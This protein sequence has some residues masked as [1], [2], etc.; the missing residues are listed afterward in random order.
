MGDKRREF[1]SCRGRPRDAV[2]GMPLRLHRDER[3]TISIVALFTLLTLVILL[4][5]VVNTGQQVDQKIKMQNAADAAS[6]AGGVVLARNMNTLAF[7]NQLLS[8]VF[9]LTAFM[10][11]AGKRRA[12]SLTP[13]IL[14][15]WERIGRFMFTPS[16]FYK[17]R[18]LGL[19]IREK[20]P[21]E[22]AVEG[23]REMVLTFSDWA[24]AGSELMLPVFENILARRLIPQFQLALVDATPEMVQTAVDTTARRHGASWPNSVPLRG[25]LWRTFGDPVGGWSEMVRRTLPAVNPV[26]GSELDMSRYRDRAKSNRDK[27]ARRYLRKWNSSVLKHF[28]HFGKM[29]QFSSLW[30]IFTKGELQR[31]LDEQYPR[32]NL[33]H[34]IRSRRPGQQELERDYMFVGVVYRPRRAD[35]MPGVFANP[36]ETDTVAFAQISLFTPQRRLVW[37]HHQERTHR[38]PDGLDGG[39]IPGLPN[40]F[41]VVDEEP[42]EPPEEPGE[43]WWSVVLQS[44]SW[45]GSEWSL[46][47]QNWSAQMVPATAPRLTTILSRRPYIH[48]DMDETL[49]RGLPSLTGLQRRDI[50]WINHH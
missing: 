48:A 41:P 30:R 43:S 9:A 14:D 2:T 13:E 6:Y 46:F 5:L 28:D 19:A 35:F 22:R 50:R 39:G 20:I 27:L 29:S 47:N 37:A 12:E 16:E 23:D 18:E 25:A 17:F 36:I 45:H 26:G 33:P 31:L 34:V 42:R 15:N 38:P 7:T 32:R 40:P 3:G 10:R 44:R 49:V 4:G 11:E 8:E 21:P 1:S 24:A